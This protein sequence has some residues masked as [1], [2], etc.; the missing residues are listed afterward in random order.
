MRLCALLWAIT[1]AVAEAETWSRFGKR[2]D[3]T[4]PETGT[5]VVEVEPGVALD[6]LSR[7]IE[8]TGCKI[9]KSFNSDIFQGFSV[10]SGH[11]NIDTLKSVVEVAQAWPAK[12][13]RLAP[14]IPHASFSDDATAKN[15]SIHFSTGVDQLH[16]AGILGK[17]VKVAVIDSGVDYRH[18]AFG[19]G[20]G[21]GFK[22]SGGYDLV[23]EGSRKPIH[24]SRVKMS[25]RA[26]VYSRV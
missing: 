18:P 17:G 12:T 26:D 19:G 16:E 1:L 5:F 15:W 8:A 9:L 21:P 22:V 7:K 25:M 14:V 4:V 11:G 13:Y 24:I 2:Y 10:K 3:D 23:G 6:T 20:F